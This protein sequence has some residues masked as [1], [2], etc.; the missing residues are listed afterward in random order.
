LLSTGKTKLDLFNDTHTIVQPSTNHLLQ[1]AWVATSALQKSIRR[2]ASKPAQEAT[3][4]LLVRNYERFWRRLVV[5]ALED[6]G[7]GDLDTV[8]RVLLAATRKSWRAQNGGD[9]EVASQLVKALC[10]APKSRDACELLVTADLHPNMK[11]QRTAF[12]DLSANQLADILVDVDCSLAERTL[13]AWLIAGTKRFPAYALPEK[14]G[15]FSELLEIYRHLGASD[16]VLEVARLGSTRTQEGHPLTLPL[17]WLTATSSSI[18]IE[19]A[20]FVEPRSI[21]G[22]PAEAYDMHTRLGKVAIAAFAKK[23]STLTA[24][25]QQHLPLSS[26]VE[27]VGTLL[28]RL[29]GHVVDRRVS[30]NSIK[31]LLRDAEAAHITYSGFPENLATEALE[32]LQ[33]DLELLHQCRLAAAGVQGQ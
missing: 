1:D 25:M 24:L 19:K 14:E 12:L 11:H 23:S 28:F 15:S 31:G 2:G 13:A 22:W 33:S 16:E 10:A 18:S 21:R 9:W 20:A 5:I 7:I 6:I 4:F 26:H 27:F 29:E 17:V 32:A 30:Y 8:R 3:S